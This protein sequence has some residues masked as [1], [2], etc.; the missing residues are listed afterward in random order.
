MSHIALN[1]L[2]GTAQISRRFRE[3]LMN[4]DRPAVLAEFD[5]TDEERDFLLGIKAG[6]VQEFAFQLDEWLQTQASPPHLCNSRDTP[7]QHD[8]RLVAAEYRLPR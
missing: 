3:R 6:S 2:V 1:V 7:Q 5:L 8:Y 4:G